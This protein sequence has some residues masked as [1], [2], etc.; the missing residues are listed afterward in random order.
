MDP[1]ELKSRLGGVQTIVATP[2]HNNYD[3]HEDGLRCVLHFLLDSGISLLTPMGTG[4]E[5]PSLTSS[6]QRR[7]VEIAVAETRAK[8][9]AAL[10]VPGFGSASIREAIDFCCF[11][12][13]VGCDGVM[14]APPFYY[15][16][17]F[18]QAYQ[19]Y[20]TVNDAVAIGI[21]FYYYPSMHPI[22]L[23]VPELLQVLRLPNVVGIKETSHDMFEYDRLARLVGEEAV[24]ISGAGEWLSPYTYLAGF[25]GF[26]TSIP[27]FCPEIPLEIHRAGAAGDI[28]GVARIV[29]RIG[30]FLDWW[31]DKGGP[32]LTKVAMNWRGLP[33]GSLR[34]PQVP[35]MTSDRLEELHSLMM[36]LKILP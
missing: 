1:Q 32:E 25:K 23:T 34:P 8:S 12:R 31:W 29:R 14:L 2:F 36:E 15:R 10:V 33:A 26:T 20:K 13:D 24:L 28:D 6:E 35:T 19:F 3:L 30:P 4:G 22:K 17:G 11:A 7:V 21:I 5:F 9:L 18:Q 16:M 27:N